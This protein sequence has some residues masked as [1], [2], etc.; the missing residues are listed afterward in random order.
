[1]GKLLIARHGETDWNRERRLQGQLSQNSATELRLAEELQEARGLIDYGKNEIASYR[2]REILLNDE[3][4]SLH[5]LRD[6]LNDQLDKAKV[7]RNQLRNNIIG[8]IEEDDTRV[9]P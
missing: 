6:A 5:R 7:S 2:N 3:I 8:A 4:D 9:N 1:M